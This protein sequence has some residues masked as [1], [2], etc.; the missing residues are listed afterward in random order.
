MRTI[1]DEDKSLFHT[2]LALSKKSDVC[3]CALFPDTVAISA[4]LARRSV[5]CAHPSYIYVRS[6]ESV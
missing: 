6:A 4:A 2:C 5:C 1:I 3:W